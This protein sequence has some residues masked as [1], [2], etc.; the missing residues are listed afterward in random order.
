[1]VLGTFSVTVRAAD[2]VWTGNA[3][4]QE[5]GITVGARE[6]VLYASDAT[7]IAGTWALVSDSTAAGGMRLATPDNGAAKLATPLAA[8]ANYFEMPFAAEAGVAYHLW[9]RGRAQNNSW[10]NDSVMVQFSNSVDAAGNAKYRI[11]T[12]SGHDVNLEDCSGCGIAGWGWQDNGWGVNVVGPAI[13]FAQSGPQ[14]IRVQVK[15]DGF[16]IDE[17]VLSADRYATVSPGALKNDTTILVR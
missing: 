7:T 1:M 5:L 15:E 9:V 16:S 10:A 17:V 8:P 2:A 13:Y 6:I 12:T 11:G 3:A 4:L 14:T